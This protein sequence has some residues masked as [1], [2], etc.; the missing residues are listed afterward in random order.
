M[1]PL[2]PHEEYDR[3]DRLWTPHPLLESECKRKLSKLKIPF[4]LELNTV[5]W[6]NDKQTIQPQQ[7]QTTVIDKEHFYC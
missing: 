6:I 3:K 2:L 1:T 7:N 4:A 5:P